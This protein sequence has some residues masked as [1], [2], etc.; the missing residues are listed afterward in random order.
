M[1][2]F[3]FLG[4]YWYLIITA[5][6]II[7]IAIISIINFMKQN[8]EERLKSVKQW[9]IY[10]C[11]LAESHLGSGTGQLKMRE[12]YNMFLQTFPSLAEKISYNTYKGIAEEALVEFK[13]M[14]KTNPNVQ[15]VVT[16]E[17]INNNIITT[18]E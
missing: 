6:S 8:P 18:E 14:L 1:G 7:V 3:E 11:A 5:L 12:T 13:E 4:N 16:Q 2:F 9:A 10:A 17:Q 15:N